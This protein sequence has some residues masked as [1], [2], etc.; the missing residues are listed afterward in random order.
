MLH[1]YFV[2]TTNVAFYSVE[3]KR[4]VYDGETETRIKKKKKKKKV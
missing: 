4:A 2:F 3:Q 1:F